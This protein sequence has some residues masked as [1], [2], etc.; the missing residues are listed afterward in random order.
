M[1]IRVKNLC[2]KPD[3]ILSCKAYDKEKQRLGHFLKTL[4]AVHK[5]LDI[6]WDFLKKIFILS[7][8]NAYVERGFS[9]KKENIV[10]NINNKNL[11]AQRRVYDGL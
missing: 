8:G 7:Q 1:Q 11:I 4:I 10:E 6:L 3:V 5:G 2:S 9:I